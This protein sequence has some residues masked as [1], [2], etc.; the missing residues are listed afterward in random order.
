MS[1]S[2]GLQGDT[3]LVAGVSTGS[4]QVQASLVDKVWKVSSSLDAHPCPHP[5][6]PP[7]LQD[8]QSSVVRLL[9]IEN[10][11]LQPC[12]DVYLLPLS[13]LDYQVE[14]R[15]HGHTEVVPLPSDQ[16]S[17]LLTNT[18]VAQLDHKR[19]RVTALVLGFTDVV[20]QDKSILYLS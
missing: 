9:V 20:L 7:S 11:M 5:S 15:K 16:H 18:T 13:Y 10:L 2:Q 1:L 4:A 8:V 6:L 19:S 17:L 12:V 3:V 14:R